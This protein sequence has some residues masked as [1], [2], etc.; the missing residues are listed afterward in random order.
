VAIP[1]DVDAPTVVKASGMVELPL[2]VRWS[3]PHRQYDMADRNH[4]AR[5]YEQVL[6]EGTDDDVRFYID[7]D[8]LID[9][10]PELVLPHRVRLA[11]A[12]WLADRRGVTVAC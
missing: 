6:S 12:G 5:V 1:D 4:R 8:A 3:G 10:W 2:R 9:M 11:W 7:I